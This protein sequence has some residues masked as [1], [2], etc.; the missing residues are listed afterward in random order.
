MFVAEHKNC[1]KK[2]GTTQYCGKVMILIVTA[3]FPELTASVSNKLSAAGYF[4]DFD[5]PGKDS[6][7]YFCTFLKYLS[8][9]NVGIFHPGKYRRCQYRGS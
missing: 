7:A 9:S 2:I 5:R 8:A 3:I 6:A 1:S 4:K